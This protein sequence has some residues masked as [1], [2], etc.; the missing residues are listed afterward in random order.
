MSS[1]IIAK[2]DHKLIGSYSEV[3]CK[4]Q[5]ASLVE[6]LFMMSRINWLEPLRTENW[7]WPAMKQ[8]T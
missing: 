1:Y 8:R 5:A 7:Q 2:K 3:L 6:S 4:K